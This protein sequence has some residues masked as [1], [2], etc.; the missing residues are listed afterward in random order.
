MHHMARATD[1]VS[2]AVLR[3]HTDLFRSYLLNSTG[4]PNC[5]SMRWS[6]CGNTWPVRCLRK[7]SSPIPRTKRRLDHW[8]RTAWR[9]IRRFACHPFTTQ[10]E[11][12]GELALELPLLTKFKR[13]PAIGPRAAVDGPSRSGH[14]ILAEH[15][16]PVDAIGR[17]GCGA[18]TQSRHPFR[19]GLY[20]GVSCM[21]SCTFCGRHRDARYAPQDMTS[22]NV[23]FE[24]CSAR[25]RRRSRTRSTSPAASSR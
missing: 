12:A 21:F 11:L 8:S 17:L 23:L 25:R 2:K 24:R 7:G 5:R 16:P 10:Q 1:A 9:V 19:V 3:A 13:A 20:V 6:R 15:D 18:P 14:E 4:H 22:G